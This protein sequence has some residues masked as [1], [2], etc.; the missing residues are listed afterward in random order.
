MWAAE[1]SIEID[2]GP[3]VINASLPT[4]PAGRSGTKGQ[5]GSSST[6]RSWLARTPG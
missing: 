1:H 2:A 4:P 6:A 5:S 3:E